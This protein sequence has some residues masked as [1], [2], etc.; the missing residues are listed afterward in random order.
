MT[1]TLAFP[2]IAEMAAEMM[3]LPPSRCTDPFAVMAA[4]NG[5]PARRGSVEKRTLKFHPIP[6]KMVTGWG[7]KLAAWKVV[8]TY[9]GNGRAIMATFNALC[10]FT[11]WRTGRCD[12]AGTEIAK[13]ARYS[14]STFWSAI[15]WMKERNIVAVIPTFRKIVSEDGRFFP[16]Q[17]TNVY[18]FLPPSQWRGY[19]ARPEP[20]PPEPDTWGATPP[21]P[22]EQPAHGPLDQMGKTQKLR[23]KLREAEMALETEPDNVGAAALVRL[24]RN[25]LTGLDPPD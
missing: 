25:T 3:A 20:P 10:D 19:V 22:D 14:P 13:W 17:D 12:P 9:P 24:Y 8:G 21:L 1:G 23:I 5:R 4:L 16:Q 11:I 2:S 15:R 7:Y 6:R 18:V